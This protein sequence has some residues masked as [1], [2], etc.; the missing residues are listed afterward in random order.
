M[1]LDIHGYTLEQ[2]QAL[3]ALQEETVSKELE[4][5]GNLLSLENVI[6]VLERQKKVSSR[7]LSAFLLGMTEETFSG[8]LINLTDPI[9]L[10]LYQSI[11]EEPLLHQLTVFGHSAEKSLSELSVKTERCLIEISTL[12]DTASGIEPLYQN[13]SSLE[14]EM[15]NLTTALQN[16]LK[17][18]WQSD[19]QQLVALLSPIKEA[20]ERLRLQSLGKKKNDLTQATGLHLKIEERLGAIYD[21]LLMDSDPSIEALAVLGIVYLEDFQALGLAEPDRKNTLQDVQHILNTLGLRT[22]AD[23]KANRIYSRGALQDYVKHAYKFMRL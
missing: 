22:V 20:A 16:A 12:N 21:R 8:L 17:L 1:G 10:L 5:L 23:V 6:Q 2:I 19:R 13:I 14:N 15:A 3:L 11:H 7:N 9:L 4:K 18:A